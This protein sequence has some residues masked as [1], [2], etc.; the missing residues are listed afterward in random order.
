MNNKEQLGSRL[1][2]ILLSAGCAIG[3]GNVWK[4][5]YITGQNGGGVFLILYIIML[6]LFGIP[7]LTMEFS[8]GRASQRAPVKMYDDLEP[9]GSKWHLHGVFCMIGCIIL[10]M[11]YGVVAGW[12]IRYFIK[13]LAGD[14]VSAST[15][16]ITAEFGTMLA[17]P[18]INVGYMLIVVLIGFSV[19]AI[20]IQKGLERITKY[21]M[22]ALLAIMVIL[23]VNSFF[24]EGGK[25]GLKFFLL[26]DWKRTSEIGF[27]NV[28]IDALNQAFFT[29]SIGM[30]SM[31][32]LGSY[33]NKERSLF[34]ESITIAALD[35]F[36][37]VT[38]GLIMFPACFAYG[39]DVDSGPNLLFITMPNVFANMGLGRLWGSLFF[40]FMSFAA[41]STSFAVYEN[42]LANFIEVTG[43]KRRMA[44][45]VCGIGMF[46]LSIPCALG[47]NVWSDFKPFGEN[48]GI[49]D[50]EDFAVS[51]II[52][53]LGAIIFALFCT[54]RYGWG[55]KNFLTEAN[56]GT[57]LKFPS[58]LKPY[59]TFFLPLILIIIFI[60][61]LITV[62]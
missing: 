51:N 47:F 55:W 6:V 61:G 8:I 40:M 49:L 2:F 9:K 12:I 20:G 42:V 33:M 19:C 5:P 24:M 11:Y 56:S 43:M 54:L 28:L 16:E 27:A 62:F 37:A 21:M 17:S 53:P 31:A 15:K 10:M 52:L 14:F 35:T 25:E 23:A 48:T 32:V 60:T 50:L 3:L 46:I 30:G 29:L 59:C 58:F 57:G 7:I 26:P 18:A 1:G 34:G 41:L 22:L 45:L 13:F 44:C 36:V 38:A 4:F 39:I